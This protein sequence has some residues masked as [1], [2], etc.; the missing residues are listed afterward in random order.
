MEGLK[1]NT[2]YVEHGPVVDVG[3]YKYESDD[4]DV[5]S[6]RGVKGFER[7]CQHYQYIREF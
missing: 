6:D 7:I 3:R 4:S 1:G 2:S 5:E